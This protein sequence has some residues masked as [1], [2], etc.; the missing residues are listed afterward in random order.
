VK[1]VRT[2]METGDTDSFLDGRITPFME[3]FLAG[4]ANGTLGEGG[5]GDE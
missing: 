5:G 3:A 4:R 2:N 1:D